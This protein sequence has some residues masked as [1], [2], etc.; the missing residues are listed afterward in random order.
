[1][2]RPYWSDAGNRCDLLFTRLQQRVHAGKSLSD[3]ERHAFADALDAES[4]E[5]SGQSPTFAGLDAGKQILRFF[6][7]HALQR[8][9]LLLVQAVNVRN[10]RHQ[11]AFDQLLSQ[12]FAEAVDLHAA[13]LGKRFHATHQLAGAITASRTHEV[14]TPAAL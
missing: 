8:Q 2:F 4:G 3:G 13:A 11:F 6:L 9:Q 12:F 14:V 7:A 1:A 5:E 10:R